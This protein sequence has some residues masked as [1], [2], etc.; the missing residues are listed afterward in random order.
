MAGLTHFVE[1]AKTK[2]YHTVRD[3]DLVAAQVLNK[4]DY[5]WYTLDQSWILVLDELDSPPPTEEEL[6]AEYNKVYDELVKAV[7][8]GARLF[9][10][11]NRAYGNAWKRAGMLSLFA[12]VRRKYKR[13]ET[14]VSGD[15]ASGGDSLEDTL[16]DLMVLGAMGLVLLKKGE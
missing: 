13:M 14:L 10:S 11:K 16:L 4:Q 9:Q 15:K 7:L 1:C 3:E 8:E 6:A 12:D 2:R 5:A